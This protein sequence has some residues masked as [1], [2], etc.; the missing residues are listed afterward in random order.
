MQILLFMYTKENNII[1]EVDR[2][3][4]KGCH[5]PYEEIMKIH[6]QVYN[7]WMVESIFQFASPGVQIENELIYNSNSSVNTTVSNHS[8]ANSW[9]NIS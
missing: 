9:C 1:N 6:K 5:G 3:K 8:P 4:K 2:I 7:R